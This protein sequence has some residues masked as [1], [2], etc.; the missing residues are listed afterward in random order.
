MTGVQT[1]ALPIYTKVNRD[2]RLALEIL[3][4]YVELLRQEFNEIQ[5]IGK[6]KQ[7]ASQMCRGIKWQRELLRIN[8]F[9]GQLAFLNRSRDAVGAGSLDIDALGQHSPEIPSFP[10]DANA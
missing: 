9:E 10:L 2:E 6:L 3:A 1:C 8:T 5:S 7:L 4:R